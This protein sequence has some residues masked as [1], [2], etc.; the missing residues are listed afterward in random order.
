MRMAEDSIRWAVRCRG[1]RRN[2]QLCRRWAIR[3]GFVCPL[4]GGAAPQVR[5]AARRRLLEIAAYRTLG[6][7]QR[8][9]AGQEARNRA[10]LASDRAAIEALAARLA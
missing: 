2:G 8:G 5:E 6:A 4:H 7:W 9:P 3:G 1:H 10:E